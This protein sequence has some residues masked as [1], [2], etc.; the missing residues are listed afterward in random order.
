VNALPHPFTVGICRK[1]R[2]LSARIAIALL[3][4]VI[5]SPGSNVLASD[6]AGNDAT[7]VPS[8]NGEAAY[9]LLL[10]EDVAAF[11][12]SP[13]RAPTA[14]E[15]EIPPQEKGATE[16]LFSL[17][18]PKLL[19]RDTWYVLTSPVRWDAQD[20]LK[21]GVGIAGLAAVSLADQSIR[22][23]VKHLQNGSA[24]DA[25]SEIRRF[26]SS[27]SYATLGLFYVGGEIFHDPPAK[28]VFIDGASATLVAS[29]I[30]A[31]ALKYTV[32]RAR[33]PADQG[34]QYFTP[35]SNSNASFPSGETTQAFAV[36][37][38]IA[39]HYDSLWVQ[40]S[41]YGI[42]GLVGMARIYEDAHW[43]SD[44]LAGALIG[45][46]VGT[47]IVHFN[48][49]KRKAD[50]KETGIFITPL[51]ARGTGGIAITLVR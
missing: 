43:T 12:Q 28:A 30:I 11:E 5:I 23:Q 46:A 33:P 44:A 19:L 49:K 51:L 48:E 9:S 4:V 8:Y 45:T 25:A 31:P 10:K 22:T 34:N 16:S 38:V 37:S 20:W 24:K 35:F 6:L 15:G 50:K 3:L 32:G 26:G 29:G 27:Y 7:Q 1:G 41:S 14:A 17:D 40:V 13:V 21:V 42:A 2:S 36:A 39:A 47:A 18:F